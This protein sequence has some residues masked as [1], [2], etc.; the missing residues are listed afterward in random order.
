MKKIIIIVICLIAFSNLPIFKFFL[1]EHF[2]YANYDNSFQYNEEGGKGRSFSDCLMNYGYFL[3]KNP[4]KDL[5]DKRLYRTF[6]IKPWRF[7]QWGEY[8]FHSERFFLPYK[9]P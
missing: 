1:L 5:G 7:W 9:A 4:E 6:T 8:L 3:C 2:T